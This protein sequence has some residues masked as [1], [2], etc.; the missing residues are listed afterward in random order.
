MDKFPKRYTFDWWLSLYERSMNI[1]WGLTVTIA[2]SSDS[3]IGE[4]LLRD[5]KRYDELS[6]WIRI[7]LKESH[8]NEINEAVCSLTNR[9]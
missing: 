4:D 9:L 1:K 2:K 8:L 5:Y 6:K 3:T 7:R